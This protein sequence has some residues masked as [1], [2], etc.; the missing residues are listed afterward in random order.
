MDLV[1][2]DHTLMDVVVVEREQRL[3]IG[4]LG[5]VSPST[6]LAGPLPD[7]V[8]RWNPLGAVRVGRPL[9]YGLV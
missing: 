5:S 3:P 9:P 4:R 2:I 6:S 7:S 1:Q 8:S